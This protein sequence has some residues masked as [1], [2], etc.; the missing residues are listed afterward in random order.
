MF[1]TNVKHDV[2]EGKHRMWVHIAISVI[3]SIIKHPNAYSLI[4]PI[5]NMF[6]SL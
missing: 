4:L 6:I 1:H 3:Y 2:S 5:T